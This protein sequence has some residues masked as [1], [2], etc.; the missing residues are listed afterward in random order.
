MRLRKRMRTLPRVGTA[1]ALLLILVVVQNRISRWPLTMLDIQPQ[2]RLR[3][4]LHLR[5]STPRTSSQSASSGRSGRPCFTT[6]KC[7]E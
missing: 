3:L 4:R 2:F 6:E 5:L 7:Q 1:G